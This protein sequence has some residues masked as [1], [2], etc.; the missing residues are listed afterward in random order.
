MKR[1]DALGHV[2]LAPVQRIHVGAWILEDHADAAGAQLA[3][4]GPRQRHLGAFEAHHARGHGAVRQQPQHRPRGHRLA[5]AR[6]ADQTQHL[7]AV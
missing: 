5:R 3:Q 4:G 6:L 7:A 2:V 1:A